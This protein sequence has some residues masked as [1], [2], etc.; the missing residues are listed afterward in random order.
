MESQ[1]TTRLKHIYTLCT[2]QHRSHNKPLYTDRK[3]IDKQQIVVLN[4]INSS[5][6]PFMRDRGFPC[7]VIKYRNRP[8]VYHIIASNECIGYVETNGDECVYNVLNFMLN[9]FCNYMN[10]SGNHI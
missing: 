7:V 4:S 5:L 10:N 2:S 8:V 1:W 6:K 9:F 3:T